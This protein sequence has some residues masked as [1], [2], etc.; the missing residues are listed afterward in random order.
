MIKY[1]IRRVLLLIPVI[2]G[3]I[4]VVFTINY[5]NESSPAYTIL[6][7]SATPELVAEVEAELGLDRPYLVQLGEYLVNIVTKGDFGVSY[8]YNVPCMQLILERLP[9]TMFIGVMGVLV[10]VIIGIPMGIIAAWKQNSV[11]DYGATILATVISALPNFWVALML[12]LFFAVNLG[13]LPVS[14]IATW[15][16]FVLPILAGSLPSIAM[17]TRMT[18]TSILE[19]IRQDYV[20]TARSK[21]LSE[22]KIITH[23]VIRNGLIPV[24][25][26][27]GMITAL[28]MTGSMISER[29][30]NIPGLGL[31]L[32]NAI[33]TN[34]YIMVQSGT[35]VTAIIICVMNLITDVTYAFI[36]PRIKSQYTASGGKKRIRKAR[37]AAEGGGAS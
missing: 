14:G 24:A 2:L 6:G 25:T 32:Y 4:I 36:D 29:I 20:R 26:V 30:F 21:G 35:T 11:F 28:C 7:A 8:S 33:V 19:V 3:V 16:G 31:L 10:S 27:V 9:V 34:D 22:R 18:R 12:I 37:P 1:I 23:H 17:F 13:V 15:K 5:F